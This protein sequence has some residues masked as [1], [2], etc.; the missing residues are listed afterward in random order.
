MKKLLRFVGLLI[1][2][3]VMFTGCQQNVDI[4]TD[5]VE[6]SDGT[7]DYTLTA[8]F[9]TEKKWMTISGDVKI[10][11]TYEFNNGIGVLT[12][13]LET[14]N[15]TYKF[16]ES[17][18]QDYIDNINAENKAKGMI[19]LSVDGKTYVYK[20]EEAYDSNEFATA[21]VGEIND[22]I[23]AQNAVVKTN[24][25]KTEYQITFTETTDKEDYKDT[26]GY[27]LTLKKK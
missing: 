20:Y 13:G 18:S 21:I 12:N 26:T 15:V 1:F 17:A 25:K 4:E 8:S 3:G 10:T 5:K 22:M 19:L 24:K 16:S 7:W 9:F 2:A 23:K 11:G 6:L 14:E 27:T